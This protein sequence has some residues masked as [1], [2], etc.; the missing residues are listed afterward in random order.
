MLFFGL[1]LTIHLNIHKYLLRLLL[2]AARILF[3][4]WITIWFVFDCYSDFSLISNHYLGCSRLLLKFLSH[5]ELLFRSL[6]TAAWILLLVGHVYLL[7]SNLLKSLHGSLS[8][9][10]RTLLLTIHLGISK[11]AR[12][13]L[14][15]GCIYLLTKSLLE[16]LLTTTRILLLTMH[17]GIDSMAWIYLLVRYI[18]FSTSNL[19]SLIM[20]SP[21]SSY[22]VGSCQRLRLL[23]SRLL[24]YWRCRSTQQLLLCRLLAPSGNSVAHQYAW[25]LLNIQH[26]LWG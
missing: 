1:L 5:L 19:L 20:T 22:G 11:M 16:L 13:L 12:I 24:T 9:A 2:T 25:F 10:A 23:W 18:Y 4:S 15:V 8:T 26:F 14:S 21:V 17:L 7:T 6:S 3:W